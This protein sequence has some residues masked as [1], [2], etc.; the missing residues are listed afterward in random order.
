MKNYLVHRVQ[1]YLMRWVFKYDGEAF[2]RRFNYLNKLLGYFPV[3]TSINW[4]RDNDLYQVKDLSRSLSIVRK[5]RIKYYKAGVGSRL[6][7]L[8]NEYLCDSIELKENDV[9]IDIGANVGEFALAVTQDIK[10]RV[11]A[12]EPDIEESRALQ[13]NLKY[14]E[15]EIY[16][17]ALWKSTCNKDF[18]PSNETGD[19]SLIRQNEKA[20]PIKMKC[21]TLDDI[22]SESIIVGQHE[23]IKLI[24]LEAEGAEPEILEGMIK[25]LAR[26]EYIT[27]D[28]GAE[29][30]LKKESTLIEVLSLLKDAGFEPIKFGLPRAVMLF[31]NNNI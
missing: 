7:F 2:V 14:N 16:N 28:V 21:F 26:V 5:S 4:N 31:H 17:C 25:N 10:L 18:Y 1:I 20:T 11:L 15:A 30:G 23:K 6:N 13:L 8:L 22:L 3:N 19:S 27:V 29:R 9:V 12:F 24:K